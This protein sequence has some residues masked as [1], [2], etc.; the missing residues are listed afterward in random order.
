MAMKQL[1]VLFGGRVQRVYLLDTDRVVIGRGKSADIPLENNPFVSRQHAEIIFE[2]A[3]HI[4]QDLGGPNGTFIGEKRVRAHPLKTGDRILLG[5]HSLRYEESTPRAESLREIKALA[6]G[7]EGGAPESMAFEEVGEDAPGR[8]QPMPQAVETVPASVAFPLDPNAFSDA[9]TT[10]AAS[11]DELNDM[12]RRMTL[13]S[14]PHLSIA[15]EGGI[16][17]VPISLLPFELGWASTSHFQ[18]AGSKWFGKRA[19]RIEMQHGSWY[20]V[21]LAPTWSPVE[22]NGTRIKK[23]IKLREGAKIT[24]SGR[25]FRFSKG[26]SV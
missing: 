1:S 16:D 17:L 21:A 26:E 2:G 22:V 3:T 8:E 11:K 6:S 18:L 24:I 13:K 10:V 12:V 20:L 19:A 7:A 14:E 9:S 23:K 4:L 15:K 25:L 5:K